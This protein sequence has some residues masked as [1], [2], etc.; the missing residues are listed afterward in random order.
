[1]FLKETYAPTILAA[2]ARRLR[3]ETGNDKLRS[4]ME[5]P[6]PKS[7]ILARSLVRPIKM[8]FLSPIVLLLSM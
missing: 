8:L 7:E 2:K 6:L 1:M 4:K 5:S 3:K